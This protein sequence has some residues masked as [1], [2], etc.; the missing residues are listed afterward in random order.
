MGQTGFTS[1]RHRLRIVARRAVPP[2][3]VSSR[4]FV[5][6]RSDRGRLDLCVSR[7]FHAEDALDD[8][9]VLL[10]G[11]SVPCT[12]PTRPTWPYP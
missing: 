2:V 12:S 3:V 8:V 11:V 4:S 5:A 7:V 6:G 9:D 10:H 1:A